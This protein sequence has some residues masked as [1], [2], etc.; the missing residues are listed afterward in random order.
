MFSRYSFN[1]S[2]PVARCGAGRLVL[3]WMSS[4]DA[5]GHAGIATWKMWPG[6][7][8]SHSLV[9]AV[10][11]GGKSTCG[12]FLAARTR[13]IFGSWAEGR[14]S[15]G[16]RGRKLRSWCGIGAGGCSPVGGSGKKKKKK[17]W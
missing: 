16:H 3:A 4:L 7:G 2:G 17:S 14:L 5:E 8:A 1:K 13:G 10:R 6:E 15:A 9:K 12:S 11:A